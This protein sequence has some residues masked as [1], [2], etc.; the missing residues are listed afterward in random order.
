[1]DPARRKSGTGVNRDDETGCAFDR[2]GQ[3]V[4]ERLK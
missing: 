3:G 1:M 4:G 2:A